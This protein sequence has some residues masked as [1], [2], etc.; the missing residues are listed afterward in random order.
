[1]FSNKPMSMTPK[2]GIFN[3]KFGNINEVMSDLTGDEKLD[4]MCRER[5]ITIHDCL[6]MLLPRIE[7]FLE[8]RINAEK[9]IM[10]HNH[11]SKYDYGKQCMAT[12]Y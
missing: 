12:L 1:M 10:F 11:Y 5:K 8:K 4:E 3:F 7:K 2:K 6:P 9:M